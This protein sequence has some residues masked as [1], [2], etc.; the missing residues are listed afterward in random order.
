[1][2]RATWTTLRER[3]SHVENERARARGRDREGEGEMGGERGMGRDENKGLLGHASVSWT[4]SRL[5]GAPGSG[6]VFLRARDPSESGPDVDRPALGPFLQVRR[7]WVDSL[8]SLCVRPRITF[9]GR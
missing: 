2:D 7:S 4:A 5:V 1:M 6:S 3:E 8:P 9:L